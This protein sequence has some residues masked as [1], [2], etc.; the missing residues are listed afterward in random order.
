MVS[1]LLLMVTLDPLHEAGFISV[2]Q[3]TGLVWEV[4][5]VK[6]Q[7][8]SMAQRTWQLIGTMATRATWLKIELPKA[9]N[10]ELGLIISTAPLL[11]T[12]L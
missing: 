9:P 11:R 2:S 12:V 8:R 4:T 6:H 7:A 1:F 3:N 5:L 10:L